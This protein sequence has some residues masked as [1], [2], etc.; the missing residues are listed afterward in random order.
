VAESVVIKNPADYGLWVLAPALVAIALAILVRQVVPAL[1]VGVLVGAYM[2]VPCLPVAERFTDNAAI[3]GIRVAVETYLFNAVLQPDNADHAHLQ[4]IFFTL[5]IGG[6]V[7]MIAA[8]GGTQALVDRV[9][10]YASTSRRGQL[11]GLFAGL[12]VFFDDYANS[13]LVGPTMRPVC[14]RLKISRAKLAYIVDSTAAPVASIA[15]IGTWVGSELSYIQEGL[16]AVAATGTP[17]YLA[18]IDKM[19]IFTQSIPYRFY[20]LLAIWMVF[21]IAITGRDFGPMRRSESRALDGNPDR[22][23]PGAT[24]SQPEA[25]AWWLA[26]G[27]IFTLVAVTF[28]VLYTTGVAK[29]GPETEHTLGNIIKHSNS[30]AAILYGAISSLAAAAILSV[31]GRACTVRVAFDGA[32][33]GMSRMFPAIVV[34]VLAWA[35]SDVSTKLQLGQVASAR[36]EQAAMTPMWLPLIIFASA[37]GVSFAT[38]TSWGTMGILTPVTVQIAAN[39][40]GELPDEAALQVF[41]ASVGSVLAGSIFGDHCSPISDTTV[42][43][44]VASSCRVEEHVWTQMPYAIVTAVVSMAAGNYYCMHYGKPA[45]MGLL[46][47]AGALLVIVLL[48]G[49][50]PKRPDQRRFVPT[51]PYPPPPT[52]VVSPVDPGRP[53]P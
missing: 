20:A 29:L 52:R 28:A 38:G 13:M 23:Q 16:T 4:I 32:L 6:M 50:T 31:L 48:V 19:T 36:L 25:T 44:S 15:I 3:S 45:W 12:I 33:D 5:I 8:N 18:G 14:D 17:A 26:G 40:A 49:R 42:L 51:A 1:V 37:A 11:T 21:V 41:Y 22:D 46:I 7:G 9:S 47:G 27:P 10:R 35:L 39:L 43:S 53:S 30:Y 24:T 34:L 2:L